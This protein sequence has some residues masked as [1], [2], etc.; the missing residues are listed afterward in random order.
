MERTGDKMKV[1]PLKDVQDAIWASEYFIKKCRL[2][3]DYLERGTMTDLAFAGELE[4]LALS[5][6]DDLR[7][8]NRLC[9]QCITETQWKAMRT[10]IR[11]RRE[12]ASN[13]KKEIKVHEKLHARF[14]KFAAAYETQEAALEAMLDANGF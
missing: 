8:F 13:R 1:Q 2:H 7:L 6:D 3:D 5:D 14:V 12:T 11:K 10:A 4:S 9:G